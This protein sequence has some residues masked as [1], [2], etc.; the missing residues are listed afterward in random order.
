MNT[1]TILPLGRPALTPAQQAAVDRY[2]AAVAAM[3]ARAKHDPLGPVIDDERRDEQLR[4]WNGE[5]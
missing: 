4:R 2:E 3:T 5:D 1:D